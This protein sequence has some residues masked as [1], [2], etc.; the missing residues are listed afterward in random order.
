MKYLI[1]L[2][3]LVTLASC[4]GSNSSSSG[5]TA[6]A[7]SASLMTTKNLTSITSIPSSIKGT[8]SG[9][10]NGTP[11]EITITSATNVT[12]TRF[13]NS[14]KEQVAV[15]SQKY[16]VITDTQKSSYWHIGQVYSGQLY[17]ISESGSY[18]TLDKE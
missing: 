1:M 4:G 17:L 11:I 2:S 16:Y 8:W 13:S 5:S 6:S 12:V 7:A 3:L 10:E 18:L 14:T 9:Y 15:D